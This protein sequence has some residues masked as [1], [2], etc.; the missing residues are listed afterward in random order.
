LGFTYRLTEA[1]LTDEF[2]EAQNARFFTDF[3][4]LQ[5]LRSV[6]H[7]AN[8]FAIY[9]PSFRV[10]RPIGCPLVWSKHQSDSMSVPGIISWQFNE[11]VGYRFP[12]RQAEISAGVLNITD[13]NYRLN[14]LSPYND[15]PRA[16][17]AVVR[18]RINF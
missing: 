18:L 9:K 15:L 13:H 14:P 16:R 6:L 12:G 1:R 7:Q 17:T 3:E 8:L 11:F 5:K 4:P 2:P 10:V